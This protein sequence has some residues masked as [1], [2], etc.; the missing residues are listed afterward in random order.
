MTNNDNGLHLAEPL[1]HQFV[2]DDHKIFH[3]SMLS[4][5][6]TNLLCNHLAVCL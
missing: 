5:E 1:A 6:I 2:P 3:F 4:D